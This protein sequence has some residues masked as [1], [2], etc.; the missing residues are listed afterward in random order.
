M[1]DERDA[2]MLLPIDHA[3]VVAVPAYDETPATLDRLLASCDPGALVVLVVNRAAVSPPAVKQA[4]DAIIEHLRERA[5]CSEIRENLTLLDGEPGSPDVLLVDRN[6]DGLTI[7]YGVGEA[8]R[9]GCDV[10]V[11]L[12]NHGRIASRWAH[13]TDADSIL[14]EDYFSAANAALCEGSA[15]CLRV[16]QSFSSDPVLAELGALHDA[17]QYMAVIAM[18]RAHAPWALAV[19][20]CG[21]AVT[22]N[23][24]MQCGGVQNYVRAEDGHLLNAAC[25]LGRVHRIFGDPV[26]VDA[27]AQSRPPAGF[28]TTIAGYRDSLAEGKAVT[29]AHSGQWDVLSAFYS[30]IERCLLRSESVADACAAA[31]AEHGCAKFTREVAS[32]VYDWAGPIDAMAQC[33]CARG[34]YESTHLALDLRRSRKAQA[35]LMALIPQVPVAEAFERNTWA[36]TAGAKNACEARDL[37]RAAMATTCASDTGPLVWTDRLFPAT[38][39]P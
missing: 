6:S 25:K 4:N 8:R 18:E 37:A 13:T 27:R 17:A 10:A 35:Q 23:T 9:I 34:V 31:C 22:A 11:Q 5:A 7:A 15:V 26:L 12:I 2:A 29:C 14:P 24:Y 16:T 19:T 20:G 30:V 28:G 33:M 38:L 21:V 32:A 36:G 39:T 3:D 1:H